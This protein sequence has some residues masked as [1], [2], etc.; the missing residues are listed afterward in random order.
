[1]SIELHPL[2]YMEP[3]IWPKSR[4][5]KEINKY[6]D[7]QYDIGRDLVVQITGKM[8]KPLDPHT[9]WSC[10]C[11][12]CQTPVYAKDTLMEVRRKWQHIKS[13]DQVANPWRPK[14]A[15]R[16]LELHG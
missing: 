11:P 4:L 15:S 6:I 9:S 2:V 5:V 12:A 10:P 7:K 13:Q 16:V 8:W 1:M 14:F 3:H